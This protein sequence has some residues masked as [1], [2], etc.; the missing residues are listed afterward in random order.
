MPRFYLH[1]RDGTD[2]ALDEEGHE[3]PDMET[4]W[5]T[6]LEAARDI[7]GNEIKSGGVMDLRY[8]IDAENEGGEVLY[9]LPFRHAV[10][11]IPDSA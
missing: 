5:K 3:L 2:E 1:L 10:S 4:L 8:R 7:M 9:T 11:I 6:V